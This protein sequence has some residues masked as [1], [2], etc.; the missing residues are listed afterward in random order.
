MDSNVDAEWNALF[1]LPSDTTSFDLTTLNGLQDSDGFDSPL[2]SVSGQ[3]TPGDGQHALQLGDGLQALVSSIELGD[4]TTIIAPV[5]KLGGR[6]SKE[7]VQML[8]HWLAAHKARPYPTNEEM[9]MLQQRTAL[10][11]TQIA[12]WFANARRRGKFARA[13]SSYS[14]P[15]TPSKPVDIAPR[16]DTPAPKQ[17]MRYMN[18]ME[19]WQS[20]PPEHEPA[21]ASAIARAVESNGG[22]SLRT[23]PPH[24]LQKACA[25]TNLQRSGRGC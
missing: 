5:P 13:P 3:S 14:S 6:F 24:Y 22:V 1:N 10:N 7:V 17:S 12:N 8:R 16:P 2:V 4:S 15:S 19:R 23:S 21:T 9:E 11:K 18:P 25:S 20:S